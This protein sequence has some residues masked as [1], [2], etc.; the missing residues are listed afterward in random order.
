MP[1]SRAIRRSASLLISSSPAERL[2]HTRALFARS[3]AVEIP[4]PALGSIVL[5][6]DQVETVRRV[7][8]HLR[9]D[10]GAL[11]ADDVGT[12]KTYMALAVAR[13]WNRPLIVAPASLRTTWEQA[14]RR[15]VVHC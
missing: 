2:Q 4:S 1:L 6:L 12:G 15:A 13:E 9:R 11:L 8:A 10:G 7:R 3:A 5:R 14:A